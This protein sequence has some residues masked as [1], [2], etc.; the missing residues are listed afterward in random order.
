LKDKILI[1]TVILSIGCLAIAVIASQ[2]VNRNQQDLVQERYKRMVAEESLQKAQ[3]KVK[4]LRNDIVNV[5]NQVQGLQTILEKEKTLSS[6]LRTELEKLDKLNE[7]LENEPKKALVSESD[8][9][10]VDAQP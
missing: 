2:K 8:I 1:L 4:I 10:K 7:V 3:T 9:F 5:Q 6:D